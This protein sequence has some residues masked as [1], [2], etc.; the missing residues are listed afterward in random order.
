MKTSERSSS[1]TSIFA[2][3]GTITA[4]PIPGYDNK[5]FIN[6]CALGRY[7]EQC[8]G[9]G[10]REKSWC[11]EPRNLMPLA[12]DYSGNVFRFMKLE[13]LMAG[14]DSEPAGTCYEWEEHILRS[15]K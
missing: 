3:I 12:T 10:A 5:V 11:I 14:V 2:C 1:S 13:E 8:D 15:E 7:C 4:V 9:D 6:L